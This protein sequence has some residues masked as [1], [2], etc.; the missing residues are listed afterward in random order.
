MSDVLMVDIGRK[1]KIARVM[2][3]E[4]IRQVF[5]STGVTES[6]ISRAENGRTI[7]FPTA[8]RLA[9]HYDISLDSLVDN[10]TVLAAQVSD[11]DG[12]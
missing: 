5:Q 12:E 2:K 1:L 10:R 8:V 6:T 4:T 3:G 7:I 9:E 11:K